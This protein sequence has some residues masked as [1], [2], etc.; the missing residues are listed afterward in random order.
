MRL[1]QTAA[2]KIVRR[3]AAALSVNMSET[4]TTSEFSV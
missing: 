3:L 1:T 4:P 2:S